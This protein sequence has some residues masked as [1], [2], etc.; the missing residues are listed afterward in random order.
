M[1]TSNRNGGKLMNRLGLTTI[2]TVA[3]AIGLLAAAPAQ[4]APIIDDIRVDFQN[5]SGGNVGTNAFPNWNVVALP[6]GNAS[7]STNNL[8]DFQDGLGTGISL[9]IPR[10]R[11]LDIPSSTYFP[12]VASNTSVDWD[13]DA[14]IKDGACTGFNLTST[15]TIGGLDTNLRYTIEVISYINHAPVGTS[16]FTLQ[17]AGAAESKSWNAYTA[18]TNYVND[19]APDVVMTWTDQTPDANGKLTLT[20]GKTDPSIDTVINAMRITS[21]PEPSA[22]TLVGFG[23]LGML[24]LGRARRQK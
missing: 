4:A 17:G 13:V 9:E 2:L 23:L 6:S 12:A 7:Y 19:V 24:M 20:I 1:K 18:Y 11:G 8:I 14:A 15:L 16:T 5:T 10:L 3:L 21:I 22:L